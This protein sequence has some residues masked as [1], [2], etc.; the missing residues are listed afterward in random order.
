MLSLVFL[1][2][3]M[4]FFL[5]GIIYTPSSTPST[6]LDLP[7]RLISWDIYSIHLPGSI[8]RTIILRFLLNPLTIH[9]P[10]V[11]YRTDILRTLYSILNPS[12][13]L[14]S[15]EGLISWDF[16]TPSSTHPHTWIHLKDWYPE[17]ST[18]SSTHLPTWILL[19]SWYPENCTPS[20][21]HSPTWINLKDWYPEN[22]LLHPLPIQLPGVIWWTDILRTLYTPSS[23]YP[24]S[25]SHLKE[26]YH[27][28]SLY[29]ILYLST[30]L[31]SSKGLISW[32]LYSILYLSTYLES[33]E[34]LISWELSILHPLPIDIPGVIWRTDILRTLCS[35]LSAWTLIS[36][37][38]KLFIYHSI[39]NI[40]LK[41][42]NKQCCF[43]ILNKPVLKTYLIVSSMSRLAWR[44]LSGAGPRQLE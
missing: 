37:R 7:V 23:I 29:S 36:P 21:T 13:Y 4:L 35:I 10:G 26:W 11:I 42:H 41:N 1:L 6:Y 8:W 17:I 38:K 33:S 19:K 2:L 39:I 16:S 9:L 27:E 25:W 5:P 43:C 34:G 31:E 44:I 15:Y 22:S 18:P 14:K 24:P 3:L 32:G 20:S 40:C 28:V 30:Y 12:I